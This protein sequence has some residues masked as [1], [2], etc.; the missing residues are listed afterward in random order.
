VYKDTAVV[1]GRN[2]FPEVIYFLKISNNP[3]V[4]IS[5]IPEPK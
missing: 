5:P 4:A 2:V 3:N 1:T